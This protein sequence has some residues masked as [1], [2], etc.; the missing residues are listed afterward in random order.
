MKVFQPVIH[1][2]GRAY[3]RTMIKTHTIMK[4]EDVGDLLV[5][6]VKPLLQPGDIIFMG[7]KATAIS[8]GRAL[9]AA[10]VKP[11]ALAR[12][13]VRFVYQTPYGVG[14]SIAETMEMAVREVGTVRIL[15]AAV[16]AGFFKLFGVKGVFYRIA[17]RRARSIDGPGDYVLPPY[18]KY[19]VL[20]VLNPDEVCRKASAKVGAPVAIV[21]ANDFGFNLIGVSEPW[22]G[23]FPW[24][25]V[26]KD[27]P[28]GQSDQSTPFGI[29]RP[30][31]AEAVAEVA[32]GADAGSRAG[33]A[34]RE[35]PRATGEGR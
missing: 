8:L 30:L 9:P 35:R 16:I 10:D 20:A 31:P 19:V 13:L 32:T 21:D 23:K 17:G 22:L 2:R 6:Y 24:A 1:V 34:Q 33:S 27:N 3:E 14:L 18:N 15:L 5:R 7:E 28:A 11:G 29:I 12:F 25:E 26:L 4:G